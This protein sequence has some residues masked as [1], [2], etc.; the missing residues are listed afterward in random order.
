[1]IEFLNLFRIKCLVAFFESI[2]FAKVCCHYYR[3]PLFRKQDLS[4]FLYYFFKN[5][6]KVSKKWLLDQQEEDLYQYGETPLTTLA[7]IAQR[8]ALTE[9][10]VVYELGAGRFRGA[11]W[12]AHFIGCNVIGIEQIP[13]FVE[14]AREIQKDYQIQNLEII[15][16]D[17]LKQRYEK[18]SAIYLYGTCLDDKTIRLLVKKFISEL[19]SG[20]KIITV[21]Y[22][23]E[24]Y[25]DSNDRSQ[26]DLIDQF[27]V[28]F[29]WGKGDVYLHL[30]K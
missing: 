7:T 8:S 15:Q 20:S 14:K 25:L 23:L 29:V 27:Q 26:I 30:R 12:L 17:F 13:F 5:P 1:M 11:F 21:S 24:D 2:E 28:S 3:D 19:S 22:S 18:G 10:D 6:Y 9:K 4:L 16:G